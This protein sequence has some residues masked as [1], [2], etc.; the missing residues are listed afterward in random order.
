MIASLIHARQR[1]AR[2]LTI[3]HRKA[4]AACIIRRAEQ[5]NA[6][7]SDSHGGSVGT[8][9]ADAIVLANAIG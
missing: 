7:Q 1:C 3:I 6:A 4:D 2:R 9:A 5:G 8:K